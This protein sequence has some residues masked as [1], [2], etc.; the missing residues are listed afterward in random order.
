MGP[1]HSAKFFKWRNEKS[2]SRFAYRKTDAA[3]AVSVRA[4]NHVPAIKV[5]AGCDEALGESFLDRPGEKRI[6]TGL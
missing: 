4:L 5:S 3:E 1:P 6:M 2:L